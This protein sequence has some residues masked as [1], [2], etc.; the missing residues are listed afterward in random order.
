L[1]VVLFVVLEL[2]NNNFLEP[3]LYGKIRRVGSG[4]HGGSFW[5]WL[6][7]VGLLLATPLTRF[8]RR[9]AHSPIGL[10]GH[11]AG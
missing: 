1:T 2:L 6:G 4:S 5:T 3:W 11:S 9:Q 8:G 7:T 10:P